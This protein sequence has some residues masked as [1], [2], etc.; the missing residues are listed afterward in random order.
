MRKLIEGQPAMIVWPIRIV[1]SIAGILVMASGMTTLA[2]SLFGSTAPYQ[3]PS[4]LVTF[5]S[6]IVAAVVFWIIFGEKIKSYWHTKPKASDMWAD[7]LR[8][9]RKHKFITAFVAFAY[10]CGLLGLPLSWYCA[11][12][13]RSALQSVFSVPTVGVSK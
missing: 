4:I 11:G 13:D 7:G 9:M 8:A 2:T 1:V 6:W 12:Y 3:L 10:S 5:A